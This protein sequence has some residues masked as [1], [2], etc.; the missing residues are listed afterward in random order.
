MREGVTSHEMY[1]I[2]E[3]SCR[4]TQH[5]RGGEDEERVRIWI[6][7]CLHQTIFPLLS[8]YVEESTHV[9]LSALQLCATAV[10]IP[11]CIGFEQEVFAANYS[12]TK[13]Y[14][15]NQRVLLQ[16]LMKRMAVLVRIATHRF[17]CPDIERPIFAR[18][19]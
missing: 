11:L 1:C 6:E 17:S 5:M 3:G 8:L 14:E 12:I 9:A 15:P 19:N 13:L 10:M 2:S 4:V 18:I 7:V 16:K